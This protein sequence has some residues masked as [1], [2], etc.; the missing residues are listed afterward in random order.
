MFQ[1]PTRMYSKRISFLVHVYV[2]MYI[3]LYTDV[4]QLQLCPHAPCAMLL[5]CIDFVRH[6]LY[7]GQ[8]T[9]SRYI[10]IL[11]VSR[12]LRFV[13]HNYIEARMKRNF[14][15]MHHEAKIVLLYIHIF[16]INIEISKCHHL[17][18]KFSLNQMRFISSS[19]FVLARICF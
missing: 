2:C 13:D 19:Q 11:D 1:Q 7:V 18:I 16:I 8:R 3:Y 15:N 10:R 5:V 9:T 14:A 4:I 12:V 17:P 6:G